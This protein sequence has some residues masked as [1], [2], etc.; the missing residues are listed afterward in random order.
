[1]DVGKQTERLH[2]E[3]L[4]ILPILV[5]SSAFNSHC[6]LAS[7]GELLKNFE[8]ETLDQLNLN[9]FDVYVV[10]KKALT[11]FSKLSR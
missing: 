11:H 4:F 6:L 1:M 7:P 5:Y 2:H 9:F 3:I 8:A 10:E